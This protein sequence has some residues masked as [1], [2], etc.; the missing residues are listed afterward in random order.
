MLEPLLNPTDLFGALD[1]KSTMA[2]RPL[3]TALL[4]GKVDAI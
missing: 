1:H 4:E 2:F 3:E